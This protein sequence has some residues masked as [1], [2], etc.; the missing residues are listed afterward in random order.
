MTKDGG[1]PDVCATPVHDDSHATIL[2]YITVT[3]MSAPMAK[4]KPMYGGGQ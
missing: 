1:A 4:D 2:K 3:Q